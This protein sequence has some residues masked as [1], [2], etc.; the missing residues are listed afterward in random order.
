MAIKSIEVRFTGF[1]P[2]LQNNPQTVDVFNH[3]AKAKKKYTAKR[4]KTDEDVL[5]LRV[6]EIESKVWWDDELGVYVPSSWVM[7][8]IAKNAFKVAK[9]AKDKAR[10]A[11]FAIE[12]KS[13][14]TYDGMNTVKKLKD[15]S[16]NERFNTLLILPQQQVRLAKA[17][18][19]FHK[20][21]FDIGLEY[22]DKIVDRSSL[23]DV[24]EY[25]C[26]YNGFGDFR[27]TYGRA[28]LEVTNDK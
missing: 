12:N 20:W 19:I 21:S 28:L 17:F 2:L 26:K 7:A 27:P 13:K 18:P 8:S 9:I 25:S 1:A 10:G 6:L 14:L 4:T 22:D 24:L 16:K 23:L 5:A 11:I 15:I 3:F